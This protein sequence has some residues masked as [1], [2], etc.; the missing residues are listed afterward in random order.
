MAGPDPEVPYEDSGAAARY[1]GVVLPRL[2]RSALQ[3][4]PQV[5]CRERIL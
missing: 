4:A 3:G 5:L 1:D 2:T